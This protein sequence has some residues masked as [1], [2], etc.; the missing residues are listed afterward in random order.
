MTGLIG[1]PLPIAYDR[2]QSSNQS[3]MPRPW[4]AQ[5]TIETKVPS[6]YARRQIAFEHMLAAASLDD[7]D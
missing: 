6:D 4:L 7:S 2:R 1:A 5:L 3:D